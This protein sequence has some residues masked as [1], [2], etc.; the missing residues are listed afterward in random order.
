VVNAGIW[1]EYDGGD[2]I[3][4]EGEFEDSFYIILSGSVEVHK[5]DNRVGTL[6]AGDCFG[7]MGY[8]AKAKR[9]ATIIAVA[10]VSL[11]KVNATLMEQASITCQLRFSKVFLRTLIDRLSRTTEMISSLAG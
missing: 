9:T 2:R 7:E 3:I 10:K 6:H 1:Q 4:S 8:L 11:L 5:G